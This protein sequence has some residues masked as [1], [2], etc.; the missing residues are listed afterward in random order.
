MSF[1]PQAIIV[2]FFSWLWLFG[3]TIMDLYPIA[4]PTRDIPIPVFPPVT[5]KVFPLREGREAG[6]KVMMKRLLKGVVGGKKCVETA[7]RSLEYVRIRR[8]RVS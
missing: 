6:L 5:R 4:L 3:I 2:S 7:N 8:N 1:A